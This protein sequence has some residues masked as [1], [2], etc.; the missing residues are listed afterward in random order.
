MEY[1]VIWKLTLCLLLPLKMYEVDQG[2]VC[3][4]NRNLL[5]AIKLD[6]NIQ[7]LVILRLVFWTIYCWLVLENT[8]LPTKTSKE[9]QILLSYQG[10]CRYV[11]G[12]SGV[13]QTCLLLS[14]CIHSWRDQVRRAT[15][16]FLEKFL[17]KTLG[18]FFSNVLLMSY[19][20]QIVTKVNVIEQLIK[21]LKIRL[22]CWFFSF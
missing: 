16:G 6:F 1:L 3:T 4:L 8:F 17:L 11:V 5:W 18:E 22:F 12:G 15:I 2:E 20:S 19:M 9:H 10:F 7:F 13:K 21:F 14:L